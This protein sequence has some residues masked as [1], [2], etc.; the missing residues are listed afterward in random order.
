MEYEIGLC[1]VRVQSVKERSGANVAPLSLRL[2]LVQ[3][4]LRDESSNLVP[5]SSLDVMFIEECFG[6]Q[7]VWTRTLMYTLIMSI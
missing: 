1:S 2:L 4:W 3:T 6:P 7:V 5:V